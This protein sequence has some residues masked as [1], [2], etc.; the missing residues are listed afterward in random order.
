MECYLY[1]FEKDRELVDFL[2]NNGINQQHF[3]NKRLYDDMHNFNYFYIVCK[4]N[5]DI[6]GVMPFILY[7]NCLGNI[8]H[9][10]P[11]IGYGGI[12]SVNNKEAVFK[13][14]KN[15]LMDFSQKYDVKL[16]TICT[17][18]FKNYEYDLYKR[19]FEP[20][21]ERK[22][23]YQYL[24]L[25][26]D[27]FKN[28]KSKFRGNLRRNINKCRKYGVELIESCDLEYLRDWYDNVYVKRLTETHCAIYPY[29][30]FE[31]IVKYYSRDKFK[32]FYTILEDKIIGGGLYLNQGISVDNFMRVVDG[33]YMYTQ[34]GTY[35]DYASIE[36]A[37]ELEVEYYNWQSCDEVGSS[38]FKYKEDWGSGLDYHYYLTSIVSNIDKLRGTSLDLIKKEYKGI[39]VMP[40]EQ[41]IK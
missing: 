39:Y 12:A 28:M 18:P 10:M 37:L 21:F 20:S 16:M 8:I 9:S 6:Q 23:F 26:E 41:F 22:N 40:Y 31:T 25:K 30:V 24:D 35:L 27:I 7:K 32:M 1:N 5:K 36:Y 11:F 29:S 2:N 19:I 17:P 4:D 3:L 34:A 33:E 38:I 14:I 13:S 15:F